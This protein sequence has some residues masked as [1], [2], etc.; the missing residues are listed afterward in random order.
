M[1]HACGRARLCRA[2][3]GRGLPALPFP[4]VTGA[5]HFPVMR[6]SWMVGRPL[7]ARRGGQ[8][9]ARPTFPRRHWR[10]IFS[11]I[12]PLTILTYKLI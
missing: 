10:T 7:R 3:A 2:A 4:T 8:G 1:I 11:R 5:L 9:I 12:L 6:K